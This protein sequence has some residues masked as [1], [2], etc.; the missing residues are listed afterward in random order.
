[1]E[2]F[3]DKSGYLATKVNYGIVQVHRMI[4]EKALGKKLPKGSVVHHVDEN[5]TNSAN[6]NL[7]ICPS[8]KYHA[9]LHIRTRALNESGNANNRQC[10]LCRIWADNLIEKF[11]TH[12]HDEC[13]EKQRKIYNNKSM[14][15]YRR[16][17]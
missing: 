8:A 1:M 5:P 9:L 17:K 15:T 13:A 4:A 10:A 3:I 2:T 6:N 12:F 14:A 11:D 16:G 7:V